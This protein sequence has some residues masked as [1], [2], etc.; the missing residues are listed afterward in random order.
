MGLDCHINLENNYYSVPFSYVEKQVTV[1]YNQSVIRVVCDGDEIALHTVCTG[2]GNSATDR[3]H[4]P[5][6]KVYSEAEYRQ[7]HETKMTQ[8][9]PNGHQY[10]IMLLG[11]CPR[12]WFQKVRPIYGM[13]SKYGPE[14]VE[15]ALGRA[16]AYGVVDSGIIRNILEKKLYDIV[17]SVTF[18]VFTDAGNSR[19]L[20]YYES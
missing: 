2:Q 13:V 1:R 12:Y 10:F 8:I 20:S 3:L 5:P 14:L 6:N 7:R 9:G 4:L 16:L 15:K 17:D 19:D 18:P 11:K